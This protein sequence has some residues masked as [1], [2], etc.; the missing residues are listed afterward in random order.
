MAGVPVGLPWRVTAVHARLAGDLPSA[1]RDECLGAHGP[2]HKAIHISPTFLRHDYSAQSSDQDL[3]PLTNRCFQPHRGAACPPR[4]LPKPMRMRKA[5]YWEVAAVARWTEA[6]L[7][8]QRSWTPNTLT[9]L[10]AAPASAA[11]WRH[12]SKWVIA[13]GTNSSSGEVSSHQAVASA[14]T[15]FQC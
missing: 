3:G 5:A 9:A 1:V 8:A 7:Q 2:A 4:R 11:D 15:I 13:R 14:V 6:K 12:R 10:L